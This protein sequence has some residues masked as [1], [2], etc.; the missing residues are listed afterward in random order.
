MKYKEKSGWLNII[1]YFCAQ[2]NSLG[3]KGE[4]WSISVKYTYGRA[5]NKIF[6]NYMSNLNLIL[7]TS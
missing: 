3:L 6:I 4:Y 2:I 7:F 5:L 1:S